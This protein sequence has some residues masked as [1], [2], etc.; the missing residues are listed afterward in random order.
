MQKFQIL[1]PIMYN[2][3]HLKP[4]DTST[5]D[6][7]SDEEVLSL[8]ERGLIMDAQAAQ[9]IETA[10]KNA[11]MIMAESKKNVQR[12]I[13]DLRKKQESELKKKVQQGKE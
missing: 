13:E 10:Q 1:E 11:D 7:L 6:K 3:Q 2:H 12:K 4:G 8:M 5:L 9:D